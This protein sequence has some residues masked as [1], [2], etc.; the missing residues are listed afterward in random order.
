MPML[1]RD[2]VNRVNTLLAG[3]RHS[4]MELT[5]FL[6]SAIDNINSQLNSTFP[7]FSELPQGK[8]E[9]DYFP[10][11]YIRSVVCVGA[12][13]YYYT[14]D[15]EGISSAPQY[16]YDYDRGLFNMLRD[17]FNLVPE[18]Y[19]ETGLRALVIEGDLEQGESG[20]SVS[21]WQILP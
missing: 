11:R 13:W 3:E 15:E 14:T 18:Q 9:Y 8:A 1:L 6:D 20:V 17:Y 16:Q 5:P 19:Q 12:A 10:D 2:I 21:G 7:A 4:L